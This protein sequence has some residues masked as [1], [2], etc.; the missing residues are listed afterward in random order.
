M[1]ISTPFAKHDRSSS[2][3]FTLD[4]ATR[5]LRSRAYPL[6]FQAIASIA[7]LLILWFAFTGNPHGELNFGT[8][9]SWRLWW[10]L[11]PLS[12][13]AFGKAWCAICPLALLS[14]LTNRLSPITRVMPRWLREH[15]AW[16]MAGAFLAL[17]WAHA[18]FDIHGSPLLTGF[19]FVGLG[20][21][22]VVLA[23]RY[24]R[25]AFC[26]FV[27]PIGL[28][29]GMYALTSPLALRANESACRTGCGKK[30]C[31][32]APDCKL[33]E[34]PRTLDSNRYCVLCG[35]CVKDCEHNSPRLILR[36]PTSEL[37]EIRK[38]VFAEAVFV[39]LLVGM[40]LSEVIRKTPL[41]PRIM[42]TALE[43]SPFQ[44]YTVNYSLMLL[45]LLSA[46]VAIAFGIARWSAP[47][48]K[49]NLARFGYAFVPL[50]LSGHLGINFYE[51]YT[52]ATRSIQTLIDNL[53][54]PLQLFDMPPMVRGAIYSYMPELMAAQ[55]LVL[56]LGF[57][58][59]MLAIWRLGKKTRASTKPYM[60]FASA[61][62]ALFFAIY[63]FPMK[64]GC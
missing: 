18:I 39:I 10:A 31:V 36:A 46:F 7:F 52:G 42:Q 63:A 11:L 23:V 53:Q 24:E 8:V 21:S 30:S 47:A 51:L 27:C 16:V 4:P 60:L 43:W 26:R 29:G 14:D 3:S 48:W 64:P 58:A 49:P 13:F 38:P 62:A 55:Y 33:Y 2:Y 34:Y 35:D 61:I 28:M 41:Y 15:G 40:I 57:G 50:A 12:F 20:V 25:R 45:L 5:F 37:A 44:D 1:D 6:A 54:I 22:A 17:S 59:T 56:I 19:I 32:V 9:L